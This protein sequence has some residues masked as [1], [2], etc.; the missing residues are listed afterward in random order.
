MT[1]V[2]DSLEAITITP[3]CIESIDSLADA[4]GKQYVVN[5]AK[6]SAD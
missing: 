6:M 1:V 2:N 5:A 4:Q 3:S